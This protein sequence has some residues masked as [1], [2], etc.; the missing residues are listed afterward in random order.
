MRG[1]TVVAASTSCPPP[2]SLR[3]TPHPAVFD[4][5]LFPQGEK[6]LHSPPYC[7]SEIPAIDQP[8]QATAPTS[9]RRWTQRLR[10]QI[11]AP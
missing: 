3:E 2:G 6:G 10:I 5:H 8:Y 1:R 11:S 7:V 9:A 4:R